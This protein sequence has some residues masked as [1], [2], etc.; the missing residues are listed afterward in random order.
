MCVHSL[1]F[2]FW[3]NVWLLHFY[4]SLVHS[5]ITTS[6]SRSLKIVQALNNSALHLQLPSN[7]KIEWTRKNLFVFFFLSAP[8]VLFLFGFNFGI[9]ISYDYVISLP[10]P[11]YTKIVSEF[12]CVCVCG[13][14]FCLQEITDRFQ[15]FRPSVFF[16]RVMHITFTIAKVLCTLCNVSPVTGQAFV[17]AFD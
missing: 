16:H 4:T 6:A 1:L 8:L 3:L 9:L 15:H 7:T 17:L 11:G 13:Y 12:L 2:T 14:L 5:S 10:R